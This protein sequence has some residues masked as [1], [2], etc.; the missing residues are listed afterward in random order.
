MI[1]SIRGTVIDTTAEYIVIETGGIGYKVAMPL[2]T[3]PAMGESVL[4]F[5]HLAVRENA[6]DLYGFAHDAALSM[7]ELLIT[8]PKIGP[9]SA[10]QILNQAD[11]NL[12]QTAIIKQDASYLAKMSGMSKKTAE[13]IVLE[14]KDK[15]HGLRTAETYTD[16]YTGG[17]TDVLDALVALGYSERDARDVLVHIGEEISETNARIKAALQMLGK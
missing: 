7:F 4:I 5:T 13:K 2:G 6:L 12:I 1:R 11:I 8:L 14:L 16:S 15:V 9:K 3:T 17:D 10:L